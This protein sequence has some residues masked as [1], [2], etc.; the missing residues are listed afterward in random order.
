VLSR[1]HLLELQ[2]FTACLPVVNICALLG[3]ALNST[4][5]AAVLPAPRA[6]AHTP[7]CL[8]AAYTTTC[9][10]PAG[11]A[12]D[13]PTGVHPSAPASLSARPTTTSRRRLGG[14]SITASAALARNATRAALASSV[15]V[16][17]FLMV[18]PALA[19]SRVLPYIVSV[20][21]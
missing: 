6:L 14:D 7:V 11:G 8:P 2:R 5:R 17:L 16:F 10:H 15:H 18:P 3:A 12:T 13:H 1:T 21:S 19:T 20:L 4:C 9:S